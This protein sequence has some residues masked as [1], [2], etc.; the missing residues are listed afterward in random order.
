MAEQ[1]FKVD[2]KV[3]HVTGGVCTVRIGPYRTRWNHN[4]YLLE[5][6]DGVHFGASGSEITAHTPAPA[7][8]VD[9]VVTLSTRAGSR[10]TVQYGPYGVNDDIY[11][12]K[13]I[14]PPADSDSPR[15]FSALANVMTKVDDTPALV[16]V[17]TRVRVDRATYA[18]QC[19][20]KFATVRSNTESWRENRGDIHVYRVQLD[21]DGGD[22]YA[23][24]VTPV[25][26]VSPAGFEYEGKTYTYGATYQDREGDHFQFDSTM[27]TNGTPRGRLVFLD[28]STGDWAWSLAEAIND[29][30][31]LT[32]I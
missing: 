10:A 18:E 14:T 5:M 32:K 3:E 30:G 26:E 22:F 28:E 7:F 11:V 24:E 20:G 13:L 27:H 25:D 8:T 17:G 29:Y 23:A 12:V 1:T 16:P 15:E 31:P 19:H 6:E 9:D 21:G 2:D 4:V